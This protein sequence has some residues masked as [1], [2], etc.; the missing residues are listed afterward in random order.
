VDLGDIQKQMAAER[1]AREAAAAKAAEPIPDSFA[2]ASNLFA[3]LADPAKAQQKLEE[4]RTATAAAQA[5]K[6]E[7]EKSRAQAKADRTA[8][9]EEIQAARKKLADERAAFEN[10][11]ADRTSRLAA[12]ERHVAD[13]ENYAQAHLDAANAKSQDL[14]ARVAA[15]KAAAGA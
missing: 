14:D 5:A 7:A 10:E 2:A 9:N 12:R 8:A 15:V 13:L 1:E 11:V 4:L 3:A 6:I